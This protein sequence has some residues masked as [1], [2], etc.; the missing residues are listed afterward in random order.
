FLENQGLIRWRDSDSRVAYGKN[1]GA[2]F[3]AAAGGNAD[4]A[5]LGE[6]Q[7]VRN[8]IAED[9]RDLA[10]IG[11]ERRHV[12][13]RVEGQLHGQAGQTRGQGTAKRAEQA[14][15]GESRGSDVR[16]ARFHFGEIEEIVD[17]LEKALGGAAHVA[18]L[19]LLLRRE[20]AV[21]S[22]Q[23]KSRQRQDRI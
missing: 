10:L 8:E 9:L 17:E 14:F 6:L 7:R 13:R 1:G 22:V 21:D 23:Q 11:D 12:L 20:V 4:L 2:L 16:L 15:D 3:A 5:R 18:D 19:T